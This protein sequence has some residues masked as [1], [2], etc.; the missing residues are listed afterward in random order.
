MSELT[1]KPYR[2]TKAKNKEL[3]LKLMGDDLSFQDFVEYFVNQYF[4]G[5]IDPEIIKQSVSKN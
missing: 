5:E 1:K 2:I 3:N 4:E